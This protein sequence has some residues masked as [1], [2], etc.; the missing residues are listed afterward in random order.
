LFNRIVQLQ[1]Q[2]GA[3]RDQIIARVLCLFIILRVLVN[4]GLIPQSQSPFVLAQQ[5][6][7]DPLSYAFMNPL[8]K[9]FKHKPKV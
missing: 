8:G 2:G 1:L 7:F 6:I 5:N 3:T 4:V 9:H